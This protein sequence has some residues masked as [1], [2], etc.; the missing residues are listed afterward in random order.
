MGKEDRKYLRIDTRLRAH[1]R[2]VES[3]DSRPLFRSSFSSGSSSQKSSL[4]PEGV[5]EILNEMNQK[6][7]I[8]ISATHRDLLIN[9]FPITLD[10]VEISGAGMIFIPEEETLQPGDFLET[11][12]LLSQIPLRMAGTVG[13]VKRR[14]EKNGKDQ[15]AFEFNQIRD[16]DRE[17]VVQFVFQEQR[18]LIRE[19]KNEG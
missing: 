9:D 13:T 12:I 2:R 19:R 11:V 8:L 4:L 17:A 7:D 10:V 1:A 5:A 14:M 18:E 15:F 6:L 3:S 16:H